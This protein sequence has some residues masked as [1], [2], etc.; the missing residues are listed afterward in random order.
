MEQEQSC[1]PR[2]PR[3]EKSGVRDFNSNPGTVLRSR[4]RVTALL[5]PVNIYNGY[6]IRVLC[7]HFRLFSLLPSADID[8]EGGN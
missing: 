7:I 2:S 6:N 3:E 4:R 5:G 1:A 8:N